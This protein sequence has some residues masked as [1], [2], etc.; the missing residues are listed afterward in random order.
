ME[1]LMKKIRQES[2]EKETEIVKLKESR[3]QLSVTIEEL[4]E[5][6]RQQDTTVSQLQKQISGLF[7]CLPLISSFLTASAAASPSSCCF[8]DLSLSLAPFSL[9][10]PLSLSVTAVLQSV[11]QSSQDKI[12]K[13]ENEVNG[14]T[15]ELSIQRKALESSWNENNDLK[16]TIAELK[17]E[18]DSLRSQI[19]LGMPL[20]SLSLSLSLSLHISL[21]MTMTDTEDRSKQSC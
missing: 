3:D 8:V 12:T 20:L 2:R 13:L 6:S 16:R 5:L 11:S 9:T 4:Q 10:V 17:A 7:P 18:T 14:K 1:K 21:E 15:D 19:G